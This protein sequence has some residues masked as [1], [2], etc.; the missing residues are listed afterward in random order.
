MRGAVLLCG[1]RGTIEF[2]RG[3]FILHM[4]DRGAPALS[5][6][7]AETRHVRL[8][9]YI[10]AEGETEAARAQFLEE[11]RRRVV[12]I[13]SD[14]GGFTLSEDGRGI[15]LM[16]ERAPEFACE[17]P[18]TG[19]DASFFTIRARSAEE[20]P[21]FSSGERT[22]VGRGRSGRLVFPLAVTEQTVFAHLSESGEV[23]LDNPGDA[24]CGF[25][26]RVTAE[27]G[28]L[29]S[30]RLSLGE[31]YIS[32]AHALADGESLLID[33]RAGQKDVT[34]QGVSV[35]PETDWRSTF[36]SLAPGE[37]RLRWESTGGGRAAVRV[38]F[39]PLY[40]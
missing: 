5:D 21:Y 25:T 9:G 2:G 31:A 14:G 23:M 4:L 11:A 18:F 40:L 29:T 1:A 8:E 26:A 10:L 28:A 34:A 38:V 15:R 27:G 32:A 3:G 33:T 22:A 30:F 6:G 13:V 36:F 12:R 19:A 17:P 16:A 39:T 24:P 7:T 37:N 20:A 35:L